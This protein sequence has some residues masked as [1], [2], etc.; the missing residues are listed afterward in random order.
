MTADTIPTRR[1]TGRWQDI[2]ARV[3]QPLVSMEGPP[4]VS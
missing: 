2:A 1:Q 3:A 4:T